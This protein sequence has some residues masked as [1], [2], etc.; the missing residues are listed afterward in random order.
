MGGSALI[1]SIFVYKGIGWAL[2]SSIAQRDYPVM[3]AVFLIITIAVIVANFIADLLY[4]KLDP[5]IKIGGE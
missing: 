4:S 1:E 2:G 3:Q 5:R